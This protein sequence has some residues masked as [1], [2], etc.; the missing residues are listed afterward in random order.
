MVTAVSY[1]VSL[2]IGHST[3]YSSRSEVRFDCSQPETA[4]R[5]RLDLQSVTRITWNGTDLDPARAWHDGHIHL[6]DLGTENALVVEALGNYRHGGLTRTGTNQQFVYRRHSASASNLFCCFDQPPVRGTLTLS[7]EAPPGWS[8]I[9]NGAI[10]RQ[11]TTT[12]EWQFAAVPQWNPSIAFVCAGPFETATGTG[13]HGLPV[14][15]H[16]PTPQN[17]TSIAELAASSITFY[18]RI[19]EMPYPADKC[20]VVFVPDLEVLAVAVPG[21]VVIQDS[22]PRDDAGFLS[23]VIAHEIAHAW[24]GGLIGIS[25]DSDRWVLEALATYLSRLGLADIMPARASLDPDRAPDHGYLHYADTLA[26]VE[27]QI[28]RT[29]LYQGIRAFIHQHRGSDASVDDL[30]QELS[31]AGKTTLRSPTP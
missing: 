19:L 12:G 3:E 25:A 17:L 20:D 9:A 29:A 11:S 6:D 21:A 14:A 16:A 26:S 10:A 1:D 30:W 27:R 31:R 7:I 18:E 13:P 23:A 8:C 28:G 5:L 24:F 2:R 15:A 4:V 22:A